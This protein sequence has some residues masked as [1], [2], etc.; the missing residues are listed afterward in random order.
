MSENDYRI[1][2]WRNVFSSL[3]HEALRAIAKRVNLPFEPQWTV[4][5]LSLYKAGIL[6]PQNDSDTVQRW[7]SDLCLNGQFEAP[8]PKEYAYPPVQQRFD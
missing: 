1:D 3:D 5:L 2:R 8:N 4:F 6:T 7:L